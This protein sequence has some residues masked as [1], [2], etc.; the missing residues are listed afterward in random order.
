MPL[1][2]KGE[3]IKRDFTSR[4]GGKRGERIFYATA[5]K[6]T[7]FDKAVHGGTA[8]MHQK[9]KNRRAPMQKSLSGRR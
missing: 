3:E 5:N 9:R 1:S 4:Y 7:G 8:R 2:P 6:R